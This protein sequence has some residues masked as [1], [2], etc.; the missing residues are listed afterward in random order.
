MK[1]L[2]KKSGKILIKIHTDIVEKHSR[3]NPTNFELNIQKE[4][5][6]VIAEI[7]EQGIDDKDLL[8]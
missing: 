5:E 2:L 4:I 8:A 1:D 3:R 6:E 7:R